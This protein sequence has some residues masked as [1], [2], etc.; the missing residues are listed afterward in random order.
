MRKQGKVARRLG[1]FGEKIADARRDERKHRGQQ[2]LE[3]SALEAL[4]AE[5]REAIVRAEL[6]QPARPADEIER[7]LAAAEKAVERD[8]HGARAEGARRKQAQLAS[9]RDSYGREHAADLFV[10]I[11]PRASEAAEDVRRAMGPLLEA[12]ER[13][14][15][16]AAELEQVVRLMPP[17]NGAST[18]RMFVPED[19]I[20]GL[21][22]G[23]ITRARTIGVEP[24]VPQELRDG[25][26]VDHEP[27]PAEPEAGPTGPTAQERLDALV[28]ERPADPAGRPGG[29]EN[30]DDDRDV[31]DVEGPTIKAGTG[32]RVR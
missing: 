12:V 17:P 30:L 28:A 22:S 21:L 8:V 11:V 13:R 18:Y 25:R 6:G 5:H 3:R 7:E 15:E 10:E 19:R 14:A 1:E 29:A 20:G 26:Q 16:V 27:P 9:D 31:A 32:R 23:A 2:S 4:K 24:L